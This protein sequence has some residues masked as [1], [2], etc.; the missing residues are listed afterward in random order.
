MTDDP[1]TDPEATA[2][3]QLEQLG[4]STYAARTHVALV[5]LGSG[6]AKEVSEVSEVPRT[7]VYDAASELRSYGIVDV[8]YSSPR[9]FWPASAETTGR[10]FEREYR[11]RVDSVTEALG[12]IQPVGG[13]EEQRGVW[14]VH[15]RDAITDRVV[16]FFDEAEEEIVYMTV[17]ELLDDDL[18]D[19]LRRASDRGVTVRVAG[20]SDSVE[21]RIVDAVPE[22]ETFESLWSWAETPS[23]R[24]TM[25]DDER[26]LA[27]AVTRDGRAD[28]LTETAIWG[29][30]E[31]N[32]LVAVLRAIFTWRL[33]GSEYEREE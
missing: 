21:R 6:T 27:S 19:G 5:R 23:G 2:V 26:T 1:S 22:V 13:R 15:G 28:G 9:R 8:Q 33:N 12:R 31:A 11:H 24:V 25:I 14:T 16:E 30:G 18:L 4:L 29:S 10:R 7:R 20:I 17:E 32:S 3:E